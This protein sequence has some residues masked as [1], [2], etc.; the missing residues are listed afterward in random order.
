MNV[1]PA[2]IEVRFSNEKLI[3]N[4]IYFAIK[5]ALMKSGLIYEFQMK[6]KSDWLSKEDEQEDFQ[7]Q[8]LAQTPAARNKYKFHMRKQLARKGLMNPLL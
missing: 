1:H 5:N 3:F 7:Q 6:K 8:T 2:K 4:S